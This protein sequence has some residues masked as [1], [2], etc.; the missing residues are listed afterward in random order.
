M[1]FNICLMSLI[2]NQNLA[3]IIT[4]TSSMVQIKTTKSTLNLT[5]TLIDFYNKWLIYS[6]RE[7]TLNA[8]WLSKK[9]GMCPHNYPVHP[10]LSAPTKNIMFNVKQMDKGNFGPHK[11]PALPQCPLTGKKI[12]VTPLYDSQ[13]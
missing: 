8:S 7:T 9:G 11:K 3:C 6:S 10:L 4:V 1:V 2:V 12:L 13:S 5:K